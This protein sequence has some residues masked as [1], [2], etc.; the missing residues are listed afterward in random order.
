MSTQGGGAEL[1][2]KS[3]ASLPTAMTAA[4]FMGIAWYLAFELNVRILLTFNRRGLYF[5]SCVLCSSGIIIHVLS[6]CLTN[7]QI[8]NHY[9]ASVVIEVTW[10]TY[11]GS[12]S[13]VLYSRLHLVVSRWAGYRWVLPMIAGNIVL[14]GGTSFFVALISMYPTMAKYRDLN[15]A[16]MRIDKVQ[17]ATFFT[18]ETILSLLY[19]KET[20]HFL[21]V[22][23]VCHDSTNSRR[24]LLHLIWVNIFII[25]LDIAVLGLCYSGFFFLQGYFKAAVYAV[26]LRAE[27]SILNSLRSVVEVNSSRGRGSHPSDGQNSETRRSGNM[28][29][30]QKLRSRRD[31][32]HQRVGSDDHQCI[33]MERE[34]IVRH[35]PL[36]PETSADLDRVS[37]VNSTSFLKR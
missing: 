36:S 3:I 37:S 2:T 15:T 14:V 27:F 4:A 9:S 24:V 11:V 17:V 5:W 10:L 35:E 16:M 32:A 23:A 34:V 26:K 20:H 22:T 21:S 13:L 28:W 25:S 19:I 31:N 33:K 29:A 6:I 12:Q 1:Q 18:V 8:W 30:L 7:F